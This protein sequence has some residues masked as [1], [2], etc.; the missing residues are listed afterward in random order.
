MFLAELPSNA[1]LG[2]G[3]SDAPV[4]VPPLQGANVPRCADRWFSV[5]VNPPQA[6]VS[7]DAS[8]L[9]CHWA[10]DVRVNHVDRQD[11]DDEHCHADTA[12]CANL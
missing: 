6:C 10:S 8:V 5:A 7:L 1:L 9:R 3:A 2:N 11:T 12:H 4:A